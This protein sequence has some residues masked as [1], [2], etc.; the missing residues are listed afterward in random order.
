MPSTALFS[1]NYATR[2][3]PEIQQ[4]ECERRDAPNTP[5]SPFCVVRHN[6]GAAPKLRA[7]ICGSHTLCGA[8]D[9]KHGNPANRTATSDLRPRNRRLLAL[10]AL[11]PQTI[12]LS[13][14]LSL[15]LSLC[16]AI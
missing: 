2:P 9:S 10:G 12:S 3:I 4:S 8:S 5:R 6:L 13:L 15:C 7:W 14:S 1:H 11:N 16:G